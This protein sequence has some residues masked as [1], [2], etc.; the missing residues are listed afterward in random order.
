MMAYAP[1][2]LRI[3]FLGNEIREGASQERT[4][5]DPMSREDT[6]R[7]VRRG[8]TSIL[9]QERIHLDPMSGKDSGHASILCQR[10]QWTRLDPGQERVHLNPM[11][12]EDSEH[13]S[14]LVRRGYTSILCQE[15]TANTGKE[16]IHLDPT[17]QERVHLNPALHGHGREQL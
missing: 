13:T 11:S 15:R 8:Y 4:H 6:L 5:L 1:A 10:G 16:R 2:V 3:S 17:C 12:G 9:C 14:I 7:L